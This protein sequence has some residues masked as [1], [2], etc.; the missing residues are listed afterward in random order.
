MLSENLATF[1]LKK[2]AQNAFTLSP[3]PKTR[4]DQN[5]IFILSIFQALNFSE[6]GIFS[7][8][9]TKISVPIKSSLLYREPV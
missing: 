1:F 2:K 4:N 6:S 7:V 9:L 3:D 5:I 8:F